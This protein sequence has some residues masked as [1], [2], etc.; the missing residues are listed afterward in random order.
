MEILYCQIQFGE[1]GPESE[2]FRQ[3]S[4]FANLR[5]EKQGPLCEDAAQPIHDGERGQIVRPVHM[6]FIAVECLPLHYLQVWPFLP[7]FVRSGYR[8]IW[9][10]CCENVHRVL[11]ATPNMCERVK[12]SEEPTV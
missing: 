4:T 10:I 9:R 1:S 12:S 6:P 7:L 8:P 2:N 11:S 3:V 5:A